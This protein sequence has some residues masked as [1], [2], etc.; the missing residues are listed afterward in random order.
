M[1][2]QDPS[3]GGR[4]YLPAPT[5]SAR[6]YLPIPSSSGRDYL[7]VQVSSARDYLPVS[8]SSARDYLPISSS[9]GSQHKLNSKQH[10]QLAC[11]LSAQSVAA[12]QR[13]Q[14]AVPSGADWTTGLFF[15]CLD[16][17]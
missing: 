11:Q 4:D 9:S 8:S 7:P 12:N 3:L 15:K 1:V 14:A 2:V 10:Q 5:S 17:L 16:F 6:D 13:M